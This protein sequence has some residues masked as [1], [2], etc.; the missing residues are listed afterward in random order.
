MGSDIKIILTECLTNKKMS[1]VP[2]C[3]ATR[4]FEPS[5]ISVDWLSKGLF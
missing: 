3:I 5:R 2:K 4:N 1:R